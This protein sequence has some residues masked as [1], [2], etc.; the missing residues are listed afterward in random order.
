VKAGEKVKT[1]QNIGSIVFDEEDSKTVLHFE[2]W[3]GQTK[4]DPELWLFK[5]N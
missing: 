5:N 1:K 3:K 2:I 4:L